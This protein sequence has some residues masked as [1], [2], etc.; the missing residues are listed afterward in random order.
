MKH[1]MNFRFYGQQVEAILIDGDPERRDEWFV[2]VD[3][4]QIGRIRDFYGIDETAIMR[5]VEKK[6]L[7]N[8]KGC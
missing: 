6:I 4:Q 5:F 1:D 7:E 8:L 3:G 2:K